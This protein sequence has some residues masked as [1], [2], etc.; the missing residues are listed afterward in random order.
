MRTAA[1]KRHEG[2]DREVQ[3]GPWVQTAQRG[4][5]RCRHPP[6]GAPGH[7]NAASA[8][9][10][11]RHRSGGLCASKCGS[12][13]DLLW[14]PCSFGSCWTT[15]GELRAAGIGQLL[16]VSCAASGGVLAHPGLHH[17]HGWAACS[18]GIRPD[19]HGWVPCS[20]ERRHNAALGIEQPPAPAAA[21]RRRRPSNSQPCAQCRPTPSLCLAQR[22][23]QAA[24]HRSVAAGGRG[25]CGEPLP[26]GACPAEGHRAGLLGAPGEARPACLPACL[27]ACCP[28]VPS[29]WPCCAFATPLLS[30]AC[31]T[32]ICLPTHPP[33]PGRR[34]WSWRRRWMRRALRRGRRMQRLRACGGRWL[35]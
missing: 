29:M 13:S 15:P 4:K 25:P 18:S 1:W 2:V 9:Y 30:H 17:R 7:C 33:T 8:L 27:P 19:A 11:S 21:P 26:R 20:T 12:G 35:S 22:E 6:P 24:T 23:C 5:R 3:H 10:Q 14:W 16:S 28:L 32:P 31:I 34:R